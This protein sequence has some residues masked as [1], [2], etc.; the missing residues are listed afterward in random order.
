MKCLKYLWK[1]QLLSIMKIT[2]ENQ[3]VVVCHLPKN[4]EEITFESLYVE[5]VQQN[6]NLK[7]QTFLNKSPLFKI[8]VEY[9]RKVAKLFTEQQKPL[10]KSEKII[11]YLAHTKRTKIKFLDSED[12]DKGQKEQIF[13]INILSG[14]IFPYSLHYNIFTKPKNYD[15][16]IS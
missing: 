10:H 1:I 4:T 12:E 8:R 11:N 14:D 13:K 5:K 6:P 16:T 15:I 2:P 9:F 3:N 7:L